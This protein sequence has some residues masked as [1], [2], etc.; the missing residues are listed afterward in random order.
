[1]HVKANTLK[2]V[3]VCVHHRMVVLP[4]RQR[5]AHC[6]LAQDGTSSALVPELV[7][8]QV[9]GAARLGGDDKTLTVDA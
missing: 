7:A 6:C 4:V 2:T 8:F 9:D 5:Y 1:M 3:S